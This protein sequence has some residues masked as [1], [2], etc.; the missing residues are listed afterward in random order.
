MI[1][2]FYMILECYN[3]NQ[4]AIRTNKGMTN[5]MIKILTLYLQT[6]AKMLKSLQT[7]SPSPRHAMKIICNKTKQKLKK[8]AKNVK[9]HPSLETM[10]QAVAISCWTSS[11]RSSSNNWIVAMSSISLGALIS[12]LRRC[13]TKTRTA[14][15]VVQVRESNR[16]LVAETKTPFK[17]KKQLEVKQ[18]NRRVKRE[19]R[20]KRRAF[21]A[22]TIE[23]AKGLMIVRPPTES[24]RMLQLLRRKS[25]KEKNWPIGW[26]QTCSQ[27]SRDRTNQVSLRI[28]GEEAGMSVKMQQDQLHRVPVPRKGNQGIYS[29]R[30]NV[31]S[32]T[33]RRIRGI[34]KRVDEQILTQI[35]W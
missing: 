32:Q 9:S 34:I 31:T 5:M 21:E 6:R 26:L 15:S 18:R 4:G 25:K 28:G 13:L 2:A 10:P 35:W 17:I 11:L 22:I 1:Q 19:S 27:S 12:Q 23:M 20:S 7:K 24:K 16:G 8:R 3:L 30:T 14:T 29:K 33:P